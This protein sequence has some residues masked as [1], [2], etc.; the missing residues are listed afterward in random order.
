MHHP[1]RTLL[2]LELAGSFHS[3]VAH[4]NPAQGCHLS[5]LFAG[6]YQELA[7][8]FFS[9][10]VLLA[11]CCFMPHPIIA[12][13]IFYLLAVCGVCVVSVLCQCY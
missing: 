3:E 8:R 11:L 13:V 12:C 5:D 7:Q 10:S 6:F 9:L 2:R 4:K 1:S